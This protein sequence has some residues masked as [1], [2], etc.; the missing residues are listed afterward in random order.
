MG[1]F[2]KLAVWM[3][4]EGADVEVENTAQAIAQLEQLLQRF[5]TE[6]DLCTDV[7]N[8]EEDK[9]SEVVDLA[10][11]LALLNHDNEAIQEQGIELLLSYNSE[12]AWEALMTGVSF[13]LEVEHASLRLSAPL[14]RLLLQNPHFD[15]SDV[16]CLKISTP[17]ADDLQGLEFLTELEELQLCLNDK[18]EHGNI[19]SLEGLQELSKLKKLVIV[20]KGSIERSFA[21]PAWSDFIKHV[22]EIEIRQ[23]AY[24]FTTVD[25]SFVDA[26]P[27][28]KKLSLLGVKIDYDHSTFVNKPELIIFS[29]A[30]ESYRGSAHYSCLLPSKKSDLTIT[31]LH[32]DRDSAGSKFGLNL[33][34]LSRVQVQELIIDNVM[35]LC[36]LYVFADLDYEPKVQYLAKYISSNHHKRTWSAAIL[37]RYNVQH[38]KELIEA[39]DIRGDVVRKLY[40]D[41]ADR[42]EWSNNDHFHQDLQVLQ[43]KEVL[44]SFPEKSGHLVPSYAGRLFNIIGLEHLPN[45]VEKIQY[46]RTEREND[47]WITNLGPITHLTELKEIVL[48]KPIALLTSEQGGSLLESDSC[49]AFTLSD[50]S[51][52]S[53]FGWFCNMS[54]AY[55]AQPVGLKTPN[56]WGLYDMHGNVWEWCHD[57]LESYE[58]TQEINPVG[59][60]FL[61]TVR[62]GAWSSTPQKLRTANRLSYAPDATRKHVGF[63]IARTVTP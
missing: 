25:Y 2:K 22:E 31:K 15:Y 26:L 18:T 38:I 49:D 35:G 3:E 12:E 62:G 47:M 9:G 51:N 54:E 16:K 52:L 59:E 10:K 19:D 41:Y 61:W 27:N 55:G 21:E 50:G 5:R 11:V 23:D 20:I 44:I 8:V 57:A 36:G 4:Q 29:K 60:G 58:N 17:F 43:S 14:R 63:R 7:V 42:I 48:I 45:T 37:Q 32:L 53:D 30:P 1:F 28:L 40:Q 33:T 46:G 56:S 39:P 24:H 34:F 13:P 6:P